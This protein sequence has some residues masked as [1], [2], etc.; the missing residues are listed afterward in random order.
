MRKCHRSM[1]VESVHVYLNRTQVS[2]EYLGIGRLSKSVCDTAP[3]V[4]K[5]AFIWFSLK[6]QRQ[7]GLALRIKSGECNWIFLVWKRSVLYRFF[8]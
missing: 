8:V 7:E 3:E 6:S 5:V 1:L 2:L 4:C